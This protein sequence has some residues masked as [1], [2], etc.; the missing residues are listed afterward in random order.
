MGECT[1]RNQNSDSNTSF[2]RL[3][4][5]FAGL[6]TQQR[7]Q[8]VAMLEAESTGTLIFDGKGEI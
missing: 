8:A 5:A 3:V 6:A 1:L 2:N 7:P 4:E